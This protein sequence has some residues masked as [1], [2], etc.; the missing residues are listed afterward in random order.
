MEFFII[1]FPKRSK[2]N[3]EILELERDT[4]PRYPA[5]PK[6]KHLKIPFILPT[7]RIDIKPRRERISFNKTLKCPN[8]VTQS[9]QKSTR[10]LQNKKRNECFALQLH[11][12]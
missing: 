8:L 11:C 2:H 6:L 9:C 4:Q 7:A 5:L 1:L 10:F 12:L 3:M